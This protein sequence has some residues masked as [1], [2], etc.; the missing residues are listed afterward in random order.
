MLLRAA[1]L[2]SA[3][4]LLPAA[5]VVLSDCDSAAAWTPGGLVVETVGMQQGGGCLV[6][7]AA[8]D[9][10]TRNFGGTIDLSGRNA[11]HLWLHSPAASGKSVALTLT[12]ENGATTGWDYYYRQIPLTWTGW[13]ELWLDR[14]TFGSARTPLGWNQI[15]EVRLSRSWGHTDPADRDTVNTLRLDD[16]RTGDAPAGPRRSFAQLLAALDDRQAFTDIRALGSEATQRTALAAY[17]RNR[18]GPAWTIDPAAPFPHSGV[19]VGATDLAEATA[20]LAGDY[21]VNGTTWNFGSPAI[22]FLVEPSVAPWDAGGTLADSYVFRQQLNRMA[23][24]E[25]MARAYWA[26]ANPAAG[27]AYVNAFVTQL[28]S[29]VQTQPCPSLMD[30][31][32]VSTWRTIEAG[33]RM[34]QHWP[35]AWHRFLKDPAFTDDDIILFVTSVLE[36]G[37][38][39]REN[40]TA[41][42]WLTMEMA[43]LYTAGALFPEFSAASDWRSYAAGRVAAMTD[44]AS[45][46]CQFQADGFHNEQT[47]GYHQVALDNIEDVVATAQTTG[48]AA[49]FP[50]AVMDRLRLAYR[51]PIR[52]SG[53]QR[54]SGEFPCPKVNDSWDIGSVWLAQRALAFWPDD[55]GFQWAANRG[56]STPLPGTVMGSPPA[57]PDDHLVSSGWTVQ[58]SGWSAN[59]H[60]VWFDHGRLGAHEHQDKL[61]VVFW[62][63]GRDLLFDGGGGD[64]DS[65]INRRYALSTHSHNAVLVDGLGQSRR[66][67]TADP[68]GAGDAATPAARWTDQSA[69]AYAAGWYQDGW[70][71]TLATSVPAAQTLASQRRQLLFWR[72]GGILLV[73]DD[74]SPADSA[75][76]AYEARW[77]LRSTSTTTVGN[78]VRSTDAA[79][80]NLAVRALQPGTATSTAS[81]LTTP[82]FVGWDVRKGGTD[83]PCTTVR[84]QLSGSGPQ[85]LATVLSAIPVGGTDPLLAASAD[86]TGYTLTKADG[87]LRVEPLA[88]TAGLSVTWTPVGGT[89]QTWNVDG[90]QAAS[91]DTGSTGGAGGGC[92]AGQAGFLLLPLLLLRFRA[93]VAT[94]KA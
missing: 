52:L 83:V 33:I 66:R 42:N 29:W 27:A 48:N 9:A 4:L 17:F 61:G 75:S 49:D 91:G 89:A 50:A 43:G 80:P 11:I 87:S 38:Y 54:G 36:H 69:F 46:E 65:S 16:L 2:C 86:A 73:I 68:Y 10:I 39:L 1:G 76:H 6:W 30:N 92:G 15:S 25:S 70:A 19:T 5:D 93:T 3:A 56:R 28:R 59:D 88:G 12:S 71:D 55:L 72:S 26:G 14:A 44:P 94:R 34:G 51:L 58:R 77:H 47:P 62:P 67:G 78:L 90:G 64:Y 60:T 41:D 23:A 40:H 82:A 79:L 37:S 8:T 20:A 85:R 81:G 7:P 74:L 13:R 21:T 57:L 35:E 18:S 63:Y 45:A 53:G 32:E 84:H 22:D 24:W 31:R